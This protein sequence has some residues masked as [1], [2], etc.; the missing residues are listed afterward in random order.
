MATMARWQLLMARALIAAVACAS[1]VAEVDLDQADL[2]VKL[3]VM[4][5]KDPTAYPGANMRVN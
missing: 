1:R 2:Q 5:I 3:E 4:Q